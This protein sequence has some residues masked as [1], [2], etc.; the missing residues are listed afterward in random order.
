MPLFNEIDSAKFG[1]SQVDKIY[2]GSNNVWQNFVPISATG[3]DVADVTI[4]GVVY[5]VHQFTSTGSSSFVVTDVGTSVSEGKEIEYL[6]VGG[7]GSGGDGVG[8]I[9]GGDGEGE[10][11]G[12]GGAGA[13]RT[14]SFVPTVTTVSTV[15]GTGGQ[16]SSIG[17]PSGLFTAIKGGNGGA[18]SGG[19]G[20]SGASGGGGAGDIDFPIGLATN[21]GAGTAGLGNDGGNGFRSSDVDEVSGGGGGGVTGVGGD[22]GGAGGAGIGLTF[23]D[24]TTRF[25]GGGG[26]GAYGG[27]GGSGVGGAGTSYG[28][29]GGAGAANTGSGGGGARGA[30]GG[31][32]GSGMVAFRYR[33][34]E[35]A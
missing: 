26:G 4:G 31:A 32:G 34:E 19:A 22:D 14:G 10:G 13:V 20:Q 33:I 5:R 3:G 17:L 28:V 24:A 29:V 1:A 12:G 21:G 6:V 18:D 2:F 23:V 35:E 16:D 9:G 8:I 15:V 25:Y 27:A 30:G 11:G 7:G